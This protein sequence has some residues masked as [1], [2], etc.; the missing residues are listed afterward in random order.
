MRA[1]VSASRVLPD[2]GGANQQ[3]VGLLYFHIL[4]VGFVA[5]PFEVV[6]HGDREGLFGLFLPDDIGIQARVDFA[7]DDDTAAVTVDLSVVRSLDST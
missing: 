5:N 1:R 4:G 3:N 7:G 2:P 6:V